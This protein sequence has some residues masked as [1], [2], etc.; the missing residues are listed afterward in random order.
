MGQTRYH[1][2]TDPS[3]GSAD[4]WTLAICHGEQRGGEWVAVLDVVREMRPPFS[5]DAVVADYAALLK[6]YR[7]TTVVGDKY[8][9]EFPRELFRKHGG[10]TY[11]PSE[12]SK[13]DIYLETLPLLNAHRLEL[14]DD[15]RLAAQ[16]LGLERRGSRGGKDS[17]DHAPRAHDDLANAVAGGLLLVGEGPSAALPEAVNLA[18]QPYQPVNWA[19]E[20]GFPGMRS[21]SDSSGEDW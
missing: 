19:R 6:Q 12:R 7:V 8:A 13:S 16:L 14:L 9:G 20:T 18:P 17:I 2:F 21:I 3:G 15:R 1:A 10:I 4:S 5:P 11:Q